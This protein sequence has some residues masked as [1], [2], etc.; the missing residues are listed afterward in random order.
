MFQ[1]PIRETQWFEMSGW[2][3]KNNG[4]TKLTSPCLGEGVWKEAAFGLKTWELLAQKTAGI[5]KAAQWRFP[6]APILFL[7]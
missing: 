2:I 5:K 1:I 6:E 7:N 4:Y 3:R